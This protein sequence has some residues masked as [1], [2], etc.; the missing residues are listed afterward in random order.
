MRRNAAT[1]PLGSPHRDPERSP[2]VSFPLQEKSGR[3]RPITAGR[4]RTAFSTLVCWRGLRATAHPASAASCPSAV[5]QSRADQS[6]APPRS[7]RTAWLAP[8]RRRPDTP[9][10]EPE[11]R[12]PRSARHMRGTRSHRS[13]RTEDKRTLHAP[14]ATCGPQVGSWS[15]S[16]SDCVRWSGTG[17]E[18]EQGCSGQQP[19]AG[20]WRRWR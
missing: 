9:A 10:A 1:R 19:E 8:E 15:V 6:W 14:G 18:Q 5:R 12:A 16:C 11:L 7:A 3:Q 4:H 2:R 20:M 13:A 17:S